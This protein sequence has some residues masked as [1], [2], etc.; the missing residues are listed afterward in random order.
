MDPSIHPLLVWVGS[1]STAYIRRTSRANNC[2]AVKGSNGND[3][4]SS[5]WVGKI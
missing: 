1:T 5:A 4:Y 3:Q 2:K